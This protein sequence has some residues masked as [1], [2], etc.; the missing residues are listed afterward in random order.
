[1]PHVLAIREVSCTNRFSN[2]IEELRETIYRL[3]VNLEIGDKGRGT[4]YIRLFFTAASFFC[5]VVTIVTFKNK[6]QPGSHLLLEQKVPASYLKL[7]RK[8]REEASLLHGSGEDPVI[9]DSVYRYFLT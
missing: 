9:Q 7:Q 1:M 2:G 5:N 3:V 8:V 4:I 6:H